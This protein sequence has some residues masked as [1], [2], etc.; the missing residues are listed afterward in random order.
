MPRSS[1]QLV[2]VS[3]LAALS[4]APVLL[5]SSPLSAQEPS[6]LGRVV[7]ARTGSPVPGAVVELARADGVEAGEEGGVVARVLTGDDG[8]FTFVA[9]PQGRY[10]L[11]VEAFGYSGDAVR[12]VE[13]AG[14]AVRV[15]VA[16]APSP[17]ETEGID[18]VVTRG[19]V[20]DE[21]FQMI[22]GV[23]LDAESDD[24]LPELSVSLRTVRDELLGWTTTDADGHFVFTVTEPGLYRL[25]FTA[26][27]YDSTTVASVAVVRGQDVYVELRAEP[28]PFGLG[29]IRVT[30]PQ[31]LPWLEAMG[32]Y[33]R[34]ALGTGDFYEPR[35]VREIP[36]QLTSQLLRQLEDVSVDQVR[37]LRIRGTF[38]SEGN[39]CTPD[40]YLDDLQ[41]GQ[42]MVEQLILKR[43][44]L[45]VEVYKRIH[46]I[47]QEW[48]GMN[49]LNPTCAVIAIWTEQ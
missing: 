40:L 45:A 22:S 16:V 12:V 46:E 42:A 1:L 31:D 41:M 10:R 21:D 37:G 18:V 32:F 38:D 3:A 43:H 23:V 8:R 19:A 15:D 47:P 2:L 20:A 5:T 27:G 30:A 4:I 35:E 34:R 33:R 36:A 44:V 39:P 13:Y 48:R 11:A 7:D 6:I 17:L 14:E 49:G 28:T 25:A 26:L 9:L 24:P 29:E